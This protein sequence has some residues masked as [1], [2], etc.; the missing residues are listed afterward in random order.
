MSQQEEPTME[1]RPM[2]RRTFLKRA[3][4]TGLGA[5]L[6]AC[7]GAPASTPQA[8][9][10]T[11][12]AG[13]PAAAA[14][15][16]AAVAPASSTTKTILFWYNAE[17]HKAEYEARVDEINKKF[18]VDF[19][20]ELLGGDAETKK[21]QAT[22][23]AG[24]G[25][26]DIAE[27]NAEDVVKF[28]KGE[29]AV[30]PFMALNDVLNNSPYFK[31]VLESRWARYTKDG[32]I[33]G[34]PHDVHPMVLLYH[35]EAWKQFGVDL[36]TVNTWDDFLAA[37]AK[38]DSKM[39]DGNTRYPIMDIPQPMAEGPRMLEKGFWW[40]DKNGDPTLND[41]RFKQVVE[42]TLRFKKYRVDL[43]WANQVAMFKAGQV[44][45]MITPDWLY[46]IHKQG[47]AK[48]T[49]FLA[50][51]P[52]R[53]T[54]M[55]GFTKDDPRVGTWG[56]TAA[57]IP[58]MSQNIELATEILLY[59]YFDNSEKQLEKRFKNIGILP[60]VKAIWGEPAFHEPDP[61]VGGQKAGDVFVPAAESLPSYSESWTTNLAS[62][63]WGEQDTLLWTDKIGVDEAIKTADAN[64]REQI[65]KNA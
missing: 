36:S 12:A 48:D 31:Q 11:A 58:K 14:P 62:A 13:Q 44:M 52:M 46:G 25:F 9:A 8:E 10:P 6:A 35:D 20:L 45:S 42:D 41:P 16:A 56:G 33:Y 29:D 37:C 49:E 64:A 51:S 50:K 40:T 57:T 18:N 15:T 38:V 65:K 61:F 2:N 53:V 17:N 32:K 23:M 4:L 63:A 24:S 60:P 55:P 7:G 5:V 26:P 47:T 28:M 3:G 59:L 21:L 34:A 1:R 54:R 22:L 27:L 39:P 30:I 43:D 19:K